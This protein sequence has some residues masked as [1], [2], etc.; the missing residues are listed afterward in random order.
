[1]ENIRIMIEA[2]DE[3]AK[4]VSTVSVVRLDGEPPGVGLM[5]Q[6]VGQE[7]DRLALL[8]MPGAPSA[9]LAGQPGQGG[10]FADKAA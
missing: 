7:P 8:G 5:V 10:F 9:Q 2:L 1:M 6:M 4:P 3:A